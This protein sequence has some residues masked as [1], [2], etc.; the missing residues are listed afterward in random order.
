MAATIIPPKES[1][2][3]SLSLD[4]ELMNFIGSKDVSLYI[5][6][7]LLSK[8]LGT[9]K[10]SHQT[11]QNKQYRTIPEM[12]PETFTDNAHSS[13]R[14]RNLALLGDDN[15]SDR[16]QFKVN[17]LWESD[18]DDDD[19]NS[20]SRLLI[21]NNIEKSTKNCI[22][23]SQKAFSNQPIRGQGHDKSNFKEEPLS[24]FPRVPESPTVTEVDRCEFPVDESF[25]PTE[26]G[27]NP[28]N[29]SLSGLGFDLKLSEASNDA[30][31]KSELLNK[32]HFLEKELGGVGSREVK[33]EVSQSF[34]DHEGF[35][36]QSK[37]ESSE[38]NQMHTCPICFSEFL[39]SCN[40][41]R[42]MKSKHINIRFACKLCA[43]IFR[44]KDI[45]KKHIKNIHIA[46]DATVHAL[47]LDEHGTCF[48]IIS[49]PET[50][51]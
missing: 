14:K 45:L 7:D 49:L 28:L 5:M 47:T 42:H 8:C 35:S 39:H 12:T 1:F 19:D 27:F 46:D 22:E 2:S 37:Q 51:T 18:E 29:D 43:K 16:K 33:T 44:R 40:L 13:S 15:P 38:L 4:K 34:K 17:S 32:M 41:N 24:F 23:Y 50:G 20:L 31:T 11:A 25:E 48:D 10:F 9:L 6:N 36:E 21:F 26:T 3:I 30:V